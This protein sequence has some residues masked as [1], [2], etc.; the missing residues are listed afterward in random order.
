RDDLV[1]RGLGEGA[2]Y[3]ALATG[4]RDRRVPHGDVLGVGC[5]GRGAG[6]G[7]GQSNSA[8]DHG[9]VAQSHDVRSLRSSGPALA[10]TAAD[11]DGVP[12]QSLGGPRRA[13]APAGT[14]RGCAG[15]KGIAQLPAQT[16]YGLKDVSKAVALLRYDCQVVAEFMVELR[17]TDVLPES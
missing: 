8:H 3:D 12:G 11:G 13:T 6:A 14:G 1:T 15:S 7:D 16:T 5:R 10:G 9:R 17:L 2:H 4:R